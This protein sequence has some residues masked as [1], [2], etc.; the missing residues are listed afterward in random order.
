MDEL[1]TLND[2][3]VRDLAWVMMSPS[4]L[5]NKG[6]GRDQVS[7]EWCSAQASIHFDWLRGLD[8][9]PEPLHR[10]LDGFI[11]G[12]SYKLGLYFEQLVHI[13]LQHIPDCVQLR[14]SLQ[15]HE[16]GR[17]L[18]ECDFIWQDKVGLLQ[19]W[20]LALKFYCR[21]QATK[22]EQVWLGPNPRDNLQKKLS[23]LFTEQRLLSNKRPCQSQLSRLFPNALSNDCEQSVLLRGYLFYPSHEW[24]HQYLS[25]DSIAQHHTS[26]WW[27]TRSA[28]Q[29]PC[30]NN[31][32]S[33]YVILPR[34]RWLAPIKIFAGSTTYPEIIT[35]NQ[36]VR[37]TSNQDVLHHR[38]IMIAECQP[39]LD[40]A[41]HEISRGLVLPA[42]WPEGEEQPQGLRPNRATHHK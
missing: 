3:W 14:H 24:P 4:L 33:R 1:Q 5:K 7:A 2:P 15:V 20:E 42:L 27:C 9:N 37:Q 30:E 39:G 6:W 38:T 41:Y 8:T 11:H 34:I 18:G 32:L 21:S 36:L 10:A 22:D 29:I 17:T 31:K 28:L 16:N 19:H 23:K 26:G 25:P 40:G 13:W 35:H 12:S